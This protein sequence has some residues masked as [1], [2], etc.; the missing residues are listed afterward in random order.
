MQMNM[1]FFMNSSVERKPF[2]FPVT[3]NKLNEPEKPRLVMRYCHLNT[4][5]DPEIRRKGD[6][7]YSH[8]CAG[9]VYLVTEPSENCVKLVTCS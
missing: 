9:V 1:R 7:S 3:P 6:M 8:G 4:N 2:K 5:R